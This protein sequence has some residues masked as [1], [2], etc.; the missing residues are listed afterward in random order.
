MARKRP[1]KRNTSDGICPILVVPLFTTSNPA[2]YAFDEMRGRGRGLWAELSGGELWIALGKGKVFGNERDVLTAVR[3]GNRFSG[4]K[5]TDLPVLW[6]ESV[7]VRHRYSFFVRLPKDAAHLRK[8]MYGLVDAV[9]TAK[10]PS[11][12]ETEVRKFE[13]KATPPPIAAAP[14]ATPVKVLLLPATPTALEKQDFGAEFREVQ[15]VAAMRTQLELQPL[16]FSKRHTATSMPCSCTKSRT[17]STLALMAKRPKGSSCRMPWAVHRSSALNPRPS[18][19][20]PSS[21]SSTRRAC[22]A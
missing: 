16:P 12:F 21:G 19:L 20:P 2:C 5:L 10:S 9:T 6:L 11:Q 1:P 4:V 17:S 15:E 7:N 22:T 13:A 8:L 14:A 3:N 18:R